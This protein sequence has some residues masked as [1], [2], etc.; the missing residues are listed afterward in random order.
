MSEPTLHPAPPPTGHAPHGRGDYE[1]RVLALPRQMSRPQARR[2]LAEL[3]EH[4]HWE[5]AV[6]RLYPGG[7]RRVWLRRRIIRVVRTA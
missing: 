7:A 3:A 1:Y 5:I 4:E 6:V 2:L